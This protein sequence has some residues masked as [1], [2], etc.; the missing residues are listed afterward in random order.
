MRLPSMFALLFVLVAASAAHAAAPAA[1]VTRIVER[2][3]RK[4]A[5]HVVA[6]TLPAIV[7]DAGGGNDASY[8]DSLAPE[9]ARRTGAQIITYDRAGFGQSTEAP[10]PWSL[11]E[12]IEDLA[13][14]LRTLGATHGTLL[15]S[16]SLAGEIATGISAQHPDWFSG[17]VLVDANVPEFYTDAM[18]A[19]QVQGYAPLLAE[20]RQA[21][22]TPANRQILALGASFEAVSR[23]FH[24]M[25][26]PAS[27]PVAVIVAQTPPLP[28]PADAQAW[29]DAHALFAG[30]APN[31]TL[32]I[33]DRS[34][35][36]V[37]YD[38]PDVIVDAV[39]AL[40]PATGAAPK[41]RPMLR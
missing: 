26:W 32:I 1:P 14:G 5:F 22:Q 16:H 30:K 11:G 2:D 40:R 41:P 34:S 35:H 39:V 17:A 12:A 31:R 23:A 3:G 24:K 37:A 19:R 27:V 6:G 18:I 20:L 25:A 9:L 33:A 8:W 10:G 4:I 21:P 13:A 36:D 28:D 29:R 38:R 7:L 15:V